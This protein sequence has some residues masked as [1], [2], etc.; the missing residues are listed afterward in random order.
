MRF[1][2]FAQNKYA[3]ASETSP[4]SSPM[5]QNIRSSPQTWQIFQIKIAI[6]K[7]HMIFDTNVLITWKM[8]NEK[9]KAKTTYNVSSVSS[10]LP[11]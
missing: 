7:A 1:C 5:F 11:F 2:S 6:F 3:F 4:R 10:F 8:K 9:N